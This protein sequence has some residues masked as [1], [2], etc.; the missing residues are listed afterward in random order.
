V[1]IS[2]LEC[3]LVVPKNEHAHIQKAIKSLPSLEDLNIEVISLS[4]D[5]I[6][7]IELDEMGTADVIRVLLP[8]G[9]LYVGFERHS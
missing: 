3:I 1:E 7:D 2:I 8:K 5:E 6:G 4:E 9:K